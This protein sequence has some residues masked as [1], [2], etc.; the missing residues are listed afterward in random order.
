MGKGAKLTRHTILELLAYL[1]SLGGKNVKIVKIVKYSG[2]PKLDT[3]GSCDGRAPESPPCLQAQAGAEKGR[4]MDFK[5]AK[6]IDNKWL[7]G[8][9][10]ARLSFLGLLFRVPFCL[11]NCI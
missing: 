11:S 1:T 2:S 4:H 10:C 9:P 7:T 5:S 6:Y 8:H 3:L